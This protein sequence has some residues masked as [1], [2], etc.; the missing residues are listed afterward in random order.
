MVCNHTVALKTPIT[1][2]TAGFCDCALN[3]SDAQGGGDV[4]YHSEKCSDEESYAGGVRSFTSFRMTNRRL[5]C[6]N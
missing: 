6:L 2:M 1:I 4:C 5:L 3:D